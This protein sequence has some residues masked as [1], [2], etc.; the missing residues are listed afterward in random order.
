MTGLLGVVDVAAADDDDV[1][2]E[3]AGPHDAT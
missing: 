3:V 2:E 1:E